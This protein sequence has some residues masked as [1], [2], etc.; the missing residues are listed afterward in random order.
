MPILT[1]YE[2]VS[3][4][5]STILQEEGFTGLFKGFG[6]VM[7]QYAVHFL[8]IKFSSKIITQVAQVFSNPRLF[9]ADPRLPA[10]PEVTPDISA[11]AS[12]TSSLRGSPKLTSLRESAPS[13]SPAPVKPASGLSTGSTHV[14]PER[15]GP[16][17]LGLDR[18]P[19]DAPEEATSKGEHVTDTV[20]Q[21][22]SGMHG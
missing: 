7:L 12:N 22:K 19:K 6:A 8:I 4:C 15:S 5:F 21:S 1:R 10:A 18:E 14:L 2:G 9:P 11:S 20:E 17:M 16:G 3:D 13:G